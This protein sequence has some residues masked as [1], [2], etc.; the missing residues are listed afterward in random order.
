MADIDITAREDAAD[1]CARLSVC[2]DIVLM[3]VRKRAPCALLLRRGAAPFAGQAALPGG[4]VGAGESLEDAAQRVLRDKAGLSDVRCEQLYTFGE[5]A[6][7]PRRR[8]VTVAWLAL[9]AP[10][11][12]EAALE[13]HPGVLCATLAV[14]EADG[15]RDIHVVDR[16]GAR[17]HLAFDHEQILALALERLRGKL[18]YTAVGFDLLPSFFTLRQLQD[19]HEA[20]RGTT[21]NKPAFRRRMIDKGWIAPTGAR[22]TGTSHRPAALYRFRDVT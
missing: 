18:D 6:R 21:L 3:G 2:V 16:A 20:I 4:F 11:A 15:V 19:V 10:A 22:E 14:P 1:A 9:L 5:V 7:D 17:L 12:I 13:A 8:I